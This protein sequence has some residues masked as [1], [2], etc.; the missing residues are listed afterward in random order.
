MK[1]HTSVMVEEA[2]S[3]LRPLKEDSLFFDGTLGEGGHTEAFLSCFPGL[4]AIGVDADPVILDRARARLAPFGQRWRGFR[5]WTDE[6]LADYP[7]DEKPDRILLDLGIS[8][9]HYSA[10]GRGFSFGADEPLDKIGR[11]HV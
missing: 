5:A 10:S 2:L 4:R 1:I 3:S 9:F 7:L 8:T 6:F 11:A